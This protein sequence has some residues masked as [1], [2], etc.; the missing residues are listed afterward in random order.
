MKALYRSSRIFIQNSI[1]ETFGLAPVEALLSGCDIIVSRE[2]GVLEL[3]KD[4]G[5]GDV[6][7]D[8]EDTKEIARKIKSLLENGNNDRLLNSLDREK[9]G[10][11]KR[12]KELCRILEELEK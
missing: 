2:C 8:P 7:N 5:D 10:W 11:E 9:T 3:F 6:I 12:A 4:T 1:F